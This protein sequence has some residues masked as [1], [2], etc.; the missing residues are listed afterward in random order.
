MAGV[1]CA[2]IFKNKC[3]AWCSKCMCWKERGKVYHTP[4]LVLKQLDAVL[5]QQ[6][7]RSLVSLPTGPPGVHVACSPLMRDR[8]SHE[9]PNELPDRPSWQC[10]EPTKVAMHADEQA[11]DC[12]LR[13]LLI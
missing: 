10:D 2:I 7:A 12:Y 11:G 4:D 8:R 9:P 13:Q 1:A 6:A 5:D 3:I